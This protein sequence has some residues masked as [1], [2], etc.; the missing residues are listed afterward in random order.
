MHCIL[1][2]SIPLRRMLL[3]TLWTVACQAP[4]SMGFSNQEYWSGLPYPPL[5]G[6]LPDPGIES[7][8][9][10][11]VLAGWFFTTSATWKDTVDVK[12]RIAENNHGQLRLTSRSYPVIQKCIQ[13]RILILGTSLVVQ[14]LRLHLP[15]QG[16]RF[17]PWSGS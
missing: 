8:S 2:H 14:C 7:T 11:L 15:M 3:V 6:D 1:F 16:C 5:G 17:D 10:L 13:S 9:Y 4:L 12:E